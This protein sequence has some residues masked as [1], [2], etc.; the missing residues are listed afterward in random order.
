MKNYTIAQRVY[1]V[2]VYYRHNESFPKSIEFLKTKLQEDEIITR[3]SYGD[4]IQKFEKYGSVEN[5]KRNTKKRVRTEENI[6][7]VRNHIEE[8]SKVSLNKLKQQTG[9]R[10]TSLLTILKKDLKLHPFKIYDVHNLEPGDPAKRLRFAEK[11]L[12]EFQLD[13]NFH[14]G[15]IFSDESNFNLNGGI[16][17]QNLRI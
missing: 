17:H 9:I 13:Q 10:K 11:I 4:L 14:K 5:S 2:K 6:E 12:Q 3:A 7:L 8:N 15:I 16:N 1:F